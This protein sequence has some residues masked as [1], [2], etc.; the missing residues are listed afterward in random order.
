MVSLEDK[1]IWMFGKKLWRNGLV[2]RQLS[3]LNVTSKNSRKELCK[4][5]R[6]VEGVMI[7]NRSFKR[8][9][10]SLTNRHDQLLNT[11]KN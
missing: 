5:E 8:D 11:I 4:G 2:L 7:T 9:C 6:Q 1:R 10:M 3:T